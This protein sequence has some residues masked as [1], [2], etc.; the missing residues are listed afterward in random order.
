MKSFPPLREKC[1]LD[2]KGMGM[3]ANASAL[4]SIAVIFSFTP[5]LACTFAQFRARER[6]INLS[7]TTERSAHVLLVWDSDFHKA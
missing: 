2:Q 5:T 6:R 7:S 3:R 4:L 1:D